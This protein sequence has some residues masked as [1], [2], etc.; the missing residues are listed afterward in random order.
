VDTR[1][2]YDDVV[3]VYLPVGVAV[4]VLFAGAILLLAWRGHRRARPGGASERPVAEGAYVAV[5]AVIIAVLVTV[6]FRAQGRIE[7]AGAHAGEDVTVIAGKWNWRFRY[8]AYGID[9]AGRPGVPAT[10]VVP[11]GRT[12]RF[13]ATSIDVLHAF[14][15]P[16]RRFQRQLVPG[17]DTT[18]AL[19]FPRPDVIRTSTCSM[20]CGLGHGDMR[21]SIRVLAPAEF[22]AWTRSG[23]RSG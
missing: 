17:R 5:L 23:G 11:A 20:Y 19:T 4:F 9:V 10:L 2:T 18:F 21:F 14:W 13:K 12:V 15:V 8:P 22:T 1:A 16:D 6:T 3:A 7:D